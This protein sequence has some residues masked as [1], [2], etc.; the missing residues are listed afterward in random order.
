[1]TIAKAKKSVE[2]ESKVSESQPEKPTMEY[3]DKT[4]ESWMN[5]RTHIPDIEEKIKGIVE[6]PHRRKKSLSH[7]LN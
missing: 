7:K 3:N 5:L 6:S 4:W 1:M 2:T